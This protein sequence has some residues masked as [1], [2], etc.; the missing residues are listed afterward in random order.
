MDCSPLL[1]PDIVVTKQNKCRPEFLLIMKVSRF[2]YIVL[3]LVL[4]SVATGCA[5]TSSQSSATTPSSEKDRLEPLNRGVYKFNSKLD[6]ALLKPVARGYDRITPGRV[7]RGITNFFRNLAEPR[8]MVNSFLQGKVHRGM[9][10]LARFT[11]NTTFGLG[12]FIDWAGK[13]GAPFKDEDFG[14][15]LA[16]WGWKDPNYVMLPLLGPSNVRDTLGEVVD[17]FTYPLLYYKDEPVRNTLFVLRLVDERANLL[18]TTDVLEEAAGEQEYEFVREAYR[19]KRN[20]EVRDG[21]PAPEP[22]GLE[23]LEDN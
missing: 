15:T 23:F 10:S 19:Q 3:V 8:S 18:G 16:V 11:I 14:Q 20:A 6:K 4:A 1:L 9:T 13:S 12:G 5:S 7:S 22:E 21:E 2:L 17:F